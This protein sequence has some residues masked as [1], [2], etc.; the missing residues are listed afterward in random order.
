MLRRSWSGGNALRVG[1]VHHP[2]IKITNIAAGFPAGAAAVSEEEVDRILET[3]MPFTGRVE[4]CVDTDDYM[5]TMLSPDKEANPP[6][7]CDF[8]SKSPFADV[9]VGRLFIAPPAPAERD[10]DQEV[11]S[12]APPS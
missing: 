12:T 8:E 9:M 7:S 4:Q 10:Q 5:P 3:V 1:K 2:D 6:S 11:S